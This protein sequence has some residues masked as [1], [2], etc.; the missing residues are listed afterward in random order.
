MNI[1]KIAKELIADTIGYEL[2]AK[3]AD[4]IQSQCKQLSDASAKLAQQV[5]SGDDLK[6]R[7]KLLKEVEKWFETIKGEINVLKSDVNK[8][9]DG[10]K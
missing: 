9:F 5:R 4:R 3:G 10:Y 7:N 8:K 2:Y 1:R 6:K